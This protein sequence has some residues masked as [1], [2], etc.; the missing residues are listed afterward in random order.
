MGLNQK[1]MSKYIVY[2]PKDNPTT[3]LKT[4]GKVIWDKGIIYGIKKPKQR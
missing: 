2:K 3:I 1:K 4:K